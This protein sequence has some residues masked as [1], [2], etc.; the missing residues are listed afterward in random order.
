[1]RVNNFSGAW[2]IYGAGGLGLETADILNDALLKARN[3]NID[4]SFVIDNPKIDQLNGIPV[5]SLNE[6]IP[7]SN[8]T[9]A[10]GEPSL[11]KELLQ[12]AIEKELNIASII[13]PKANVSNSA[14]IGK[15]TIIAPFASIQ[16]Q[17]KIGENVAV[18]TQ[19][20][21]GHHVEVGNNTVVSSQVNIGGASYI[22]NS[23]YIGMGALILEKIVIGSWSILGMGSVLYKDIPDG[24]IALGNPARVARK[25]DDK[26]VF[27]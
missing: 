25:N 26:K 24:V 3:T 27:K 6:C 15:G 9:I 10:V 22:G 7:G 17:A 12:R 1:M 5:I 11:R 16:S 19:A 13:S 4:I 23:S 21:I 20:I 2:Y 8:V 14:F 18:N